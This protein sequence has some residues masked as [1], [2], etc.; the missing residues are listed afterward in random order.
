MSAVP[1]LALRH[2]RDW[3]SVA[4]LLAAPGLVVWQWRFGFNMLLYAAL[5]FLTLGIGVI[6]H[7]HAHLRMWHGR[8]A[9]WANR[10]T[11]YV[12]TVWQGHPTFVF[13]PAHGANH[14]RYK[15]GEQDAARTYRFGGDTNDLKGYLLH[16]LQAVWVLF[17]LF[18]QWLVRMHR[19]HPGVW[20]Y[21]VGQYAAWLS[22]WAVLLMLDPWKATVFVILPQLHG[23]HWL[24]ATNYLQH[25]HANGAANRHM[26]Y[27]RNFEG[28]VNP[29][30]FN[31]G[32]H[33]AHHES[34]RSHWSALTQL[35]KFTYRAQVPPALNERGLLRYMARVFVGSLF[36]KQ[37]RSRSLMMAT[38]RTEPLPLAHPA[39]TTRAD[40]MACPTPARQDGA[41]ERA[42][43]C[44]R[45][46]SM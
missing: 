19:N 18:F 42:P 35:H 46:R 40:Q 27:A 45:S 13:W 22:A 21:C 39:S 14:H 23:L 34:P 5:L 6:H 11:D 41:L 16:P 8:Y 4:Y 7:N 10:L 29:L 44:S 24:L 2:W 38:N 15:H 17:P 30:L 25:A 20:R 31:I 36:I 37:W 33:T 43:E 9:R 1:A 32:L 28:A 26:D 3:Q 12:I